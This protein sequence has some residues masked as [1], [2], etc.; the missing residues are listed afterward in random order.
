M[1]I[2]ELQKPPNEACPHLCGKGCGVYASRP[3]ECAIFDCFWLMKLLPAWMK[4]N[5]THAVVWPGFVT[6]DAGEQV[7]IV[8]INFN[9]AF[10]M[11]RRVLRW[12]KHASHSYLIIIAYGTKFE[13]MFKGRQWSAGKE[14]DTWRFDVEDGKVVGVT[15]EGAA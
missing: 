4:P 14:G 9:A 13:A 1:A 5:K 7:Q 3:N 11:N 12:A 10:P 8:R 6:N 2:Q 15:V